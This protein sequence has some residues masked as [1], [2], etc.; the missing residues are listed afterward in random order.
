MKSG[1]TP[2]S[3]LSRTPPNT[4]RTTTGPRRRRRCS[5]SSWRRAGRSW[6]ISTA[7][8]RTSLWPR[9]SGTWRKSARSCPTPATSAVPARPR[10][11]ASGS[12]PSPWNLCQPPACASRWAKTTVR[13]TCSPASWRAKGTS[14]FTPRRFTA[15]TSSC[16]PRAASPTS[17]ASTRPQFWLPGSPRPGT[18]ARCRWTTP[19]SAM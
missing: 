13:T 8:W 4:T 2:S 6:T 16:G 12:A 10:T 9:G 17:K 19:P 14:G 11:G 7:C 3:P 15:P 1:W 5:P 18:A